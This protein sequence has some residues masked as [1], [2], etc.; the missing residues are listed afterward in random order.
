[1]KV[2]VPLA[3]KCFS[4][5]RNN[6]KSIRNRFWNSRKMNGSGTITLITSKNEIND[7]IKIVQALKDSDIL[8]K[9]VTKTIENEM[10]EQIGGFLGMLF[11]TLG[12]SLLGN[13]LAGKGIVR[14]GY[15]NKQGKGIV[16]A[17]YGFNNS[18]FRLIF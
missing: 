14:A 10:K 3:K 9:G 1:M 2:A 16:R 7:I 5:I 6:S 11:G 12:D 15:G 4:T 17:A 18:E 13:M 8:L